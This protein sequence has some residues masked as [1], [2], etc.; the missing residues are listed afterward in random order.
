MNFENPNGFVSSEW[1][2]RKVE[3]HFTQTLSQIAQFRLRLF[4]FQNAFVICKCCH[5]MVISKKHILFISFRCRRQP[6]L[7][8]GKG[9]L[10]SLGF[11]RRFGL[12]RRTL[13]RRRV[14]PREE[15]EREEV[16]APRNGS[17]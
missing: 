3:Y 13:R 6:R 2:S 10:L 16:K 14:A 17:L 12:Q 1:C 7:L 4:Y 8:R 9:G 5:F 15:P 11:S